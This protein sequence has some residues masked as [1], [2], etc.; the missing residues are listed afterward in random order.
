MISG[1]K[2]IKA[3]WLLPLFLAATAYFAGA[4][5]TG[6]QVYDQYCAGCHKLG[7]YDTSGT[8][9][10]LGDGSKV[11]GKY[12]AGQSGHK[13]ITL[14]SSDITNVAAFLNNPTVTTP[15]AI[16]TAS[17][18]GA[19]LG[20][21]YS[22]SLA[23]TG[24]K[25]PY[26]WSRSSGTL[27]TGL[28][29]SS[30]GVI[31]GT[32]SAAGSFSFTVKVT[33]AAAA[34]V[35]KSLSIT[36][37]TGTPALSITT[38]SLPDGA[39][40]TAY[41]QTLAAS[42]GSPPYTWSYNGSLPPGV[43]LTSGG[44]LSG[45][46]TAAGNYSFTVLAVDTKSAT[47][48]KALSVTIAAPPP[49]PMSTADKNLFLT[50][51]V[52]CHT[53]SGLENRTSAEIQSA[54]RGNVGGMGTSQLKSLTSSSIDG[55][56]RS[57]VPSTPQAISCDTCHSASPNPTPTPGSGQ[58]LYDAD[59]AGCHKLSSYDTSGSAPDLY[60]STRVD[61]YY[62]AGRSGHQGFTLSSTDISNL[63]S[64]LNNP[65]ASPTPTPTPTGGQAKYDSSCAGCHRMG[66]YDTSGT[67]PDLYQT[68]KVD[69][70]YTPGVS[71]H[72]SLT[73]TAQEISDLKAFFGSTTTPTP[74]PTPTTGKAVYDANC[75]VCHRLGTYDASGSAPNL[76]GDGS[77]V[78][79]EYTAG[80]RGHQG[81][82]L[83]AEQI[84]NL[85]TFL[86]SN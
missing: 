64:F 38:S 31:S 83:T 57:L 18:P 86:N 41:S 59:C 40:G 76:S 10:L 23:A 28:S 82:T 1:K 79:G 24:G 21:A 4:A 42:G 54:I 25:S 65:T 11:S 74:T 35:T 55:I 26:T 36:V 20:T 80:V 53:P 73:L 37:T 13:G 16:S 39:A 15:L 3:F 44:V 6:Q 2:L 84:S 63:K 47:A 12:T 27:P 81:I 29:L 52:V 46:P 68:A 66:S 5:L 69:S 78:D 50:N 8:T 67:A 34:S 48:T 77:D 45:T 61:S 62:T 56:A 30:S 43:S 14:T 85:K 17:L 75:A 7:T 70:Y 33:D 22:Q 51:C 19:S 72:K 9:D 60:Q 71:G 32:P 58:G 49:T